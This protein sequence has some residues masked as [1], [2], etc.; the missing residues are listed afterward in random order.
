LL[1]TIN[2]SAQ[3]VAMHAVRVD[4]VKAQAEAIGAPL[5]VVPI[6]S[7]CPNEVYERA[8]AEAVARAVAAGFTHV[9]FGDLF[10]ED[11]RRYREERLAGTGLTPI[12]PL[13]DT[14]PG[15]TSRLAREMVGAGLRARI[16][17]VD[18]RALDA[19][20]AGREFDAALLD[21]LP[22]S[23]D[24]CG[25]RGEFHTCAYEGPM[26]RRPVAIDTGI[27]LERDGFV[28]TDLI[29]TRMI[30]YPQRIV[31]LTEETTETLYLLGQGDRVVGVSGYT[32]RP[33]EAREKP[34]VSA[35]INAKFDKIEAL[36][37]DL[38]LAFSDLQADLVSELVRRGMSVVVFNQ[39]SVAEILQMIRM[40]GG[41]VGCQHE[42]EQLAA[43]LESGLERIREAGSRLP[44]RMRVFFEE[45]DNPLISGIR[46]VEELVEIAGGAPIFPELAAAALAKDRIVDPAEVAR[47]DPE[48]IFASW[49]G[50]KM[51]RATI[52]SRPG[53][54]RVAAVRDDRI[55]EIKSTYIL[56]PGPASLTEGVRQVHDALKAFA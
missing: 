4:V 34:K 9:A 28:F 11:I 55:R 8:M 38:V 23:V 40:L 35:F 44:R 30:R 22:A 14:N 5:W 50:K 6:P 29:P 24:P 16:T 7:P 19:R 10:L 46:W 37:P 47:R 45:W 3:R 31:C 52:V 41:L 54:E 39:R 51:R 33:P 15:Y 49:C 17:C 53:W 20:F 36:R 27:T 13:F 32:V 42:A 12:F 26:F 1:T 21:E 48:V 2:E 43:R 56:Q 25:E 18:P